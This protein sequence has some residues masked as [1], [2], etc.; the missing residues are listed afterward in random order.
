MWLETQEYQLAVSRYVAEELEKNFPGVP[1]FTTIGNHGG[2]HVLCYRLLIS[3]FRSLNQITTHI[4]RFYPLETFP[5][6]LY[7]VGRQEVREFNEE[8]TRYWKDLSEFTPEQETT[9]TAGCYFS[10][11]LR[12]GL[13]V[14]S[15][16]TN[17]G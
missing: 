6:N 11:E 2:N 15:Y 10:K 8:M 7:H 9:F 14:I 4:L 13:R 12:P 16:N 3:I 17:Y 1:A 5:T